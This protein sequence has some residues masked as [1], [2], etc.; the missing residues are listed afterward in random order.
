MIWKFELKR[1]LKIAIYFTIAMLLTLIIGMILYKCSYQDQDNYFNFID[2]LPQF[3]INGLGIKTD[4]NYSLYDFYAILT[5]FVLIIAA[6]FATFLGF[7][8]IQRDKKDDACIFYYKKPINKDS[9][10]KQKIFAGLILLLSSSLIYHI[11]ASL[12]ILIIHEKYYFKMMLYIDSSIFL[13]ELVFLLFGILVGLFINKK[14]SF[15]APS[16]I[17]IFIFEFI[18]ILSRAFNLTVLKY[19]NPFSYFNVLDIVITQ[20][21]QY[22]F[23][24]ITTF[25]VIFLYNFIV[26]LYNSNNSDN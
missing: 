15:I 5:N 18:N 25:L 6:L 3:I 9:I 22:R 26:G 17:T 19:I 11:S 13:L 20:K 7:F 21:Y 24:V 2:K 1:S 10:I 14:R 23:I 16:I 4:G 8:G 12:I